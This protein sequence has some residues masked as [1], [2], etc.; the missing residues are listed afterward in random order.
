[1]KKIV[2]GLFALIALAGCTSGSPSEY[3]SG[4]ITFQVNGKPL[5]C[6]VNNSNTR[7]ETM[8]CDWVA[9]HK[10]DK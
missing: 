8:S 7:S 3:N 1:M 5:L 6:F 2:I 4:L 10:D 9:Y